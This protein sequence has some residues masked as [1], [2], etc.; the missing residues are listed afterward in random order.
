MDHAYEEDSVRKWQEQELE[1]DITEISN[2]LTY[3]RY[4]MNKGPMR[5]LF[6]NVRLSEYILL[7]SI[8]H[9]CES[10][11]IYQGRI[12]LKD[13]A[14]RMRLTIRQTSG[15]VSDLKN[16]GMLQ[17]SHDGNGSEGTYVTITEAGKK[18]LEE[19]QEILKDFY[20]RVIS[21]YG[22]ERL[23]Q[24]LL[25]MRELE[26]IMSSE[27]EKMEEEEDANGDFDE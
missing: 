8:V 11:D 17:W 20:G 16:K 18:Q 13:L 19:Q 1:E 22:R 23:V 3:L 24:L 21:R 5:K 12:Y 25:Q 4:Q 14:E 26:T 6:G 10:A 7:H 27:M 2:E 9:Q 15:L